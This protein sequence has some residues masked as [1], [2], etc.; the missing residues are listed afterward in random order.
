[1]GRAG[2]LLLSPPVAE[3]GAPVFFTGAVWLVIL[4]EI[5]WNVCWT[6]ST[7]KNDLTVIVT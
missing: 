3:G 1:M 4:E 6:S 5:E 7:S 2:S